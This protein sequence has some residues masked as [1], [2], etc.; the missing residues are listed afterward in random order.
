MSQL[1]VPDD[2]FLFSSESVTEGHSDKMCDS[3]SDV[4]LD[5]SLEQAPNSK[6]AV[7]Q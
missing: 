5:A 2:H 7:R 6:V 3:F 1:I 4:I